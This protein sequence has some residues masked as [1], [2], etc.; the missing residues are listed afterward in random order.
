MKTT[1][2]AAGVVLVLS[3]VSACGSQDD[4]ADDGNAQVTVE[5]PPDSSTTSI[6]STTTPTTEPPSTSTTKAPPLAF[7]ATP[8][9]YEARVALF[10]ELVGETVGTFA[11]IEGSHV[12]GA[13]VEGGNAVGYILGEDDTVL[14]TA[15][16]VP[17]DEGQTQVSTP[18]RLLSIVVTSGLAP[19]DADAGL[20]VFRREVLDDL[21]TIAGPITQFD[22]GPPFFELAATVTADGI[23]FAAVP[24]GADSMFMGDFKERLATLAGTD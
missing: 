24:P 15:V 8:D 14:A 20:E 4:T 2:L 18:T 19:D 6:E 23:L 21:S 17:I 7:E 22:G 3:F 9:E 1:S 16:Y 13:E 10:A 11:P 5:T 12:V